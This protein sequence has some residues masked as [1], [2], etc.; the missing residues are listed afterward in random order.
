MNYH[1]YILYSPK[2]DKYYVGQT[3]NMKKRLLSHN[4]ISDLSY[5]SK[6]RPWELKLNLCFKTRANAMSAEK[7]LKKK[8]RDFI[9]RTFSDKDLQ[10]YI[11]NKFNS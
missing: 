1:C 8:P 7:Y 11:L 4:S 6:Y 3:K 9:K 2:F 5:T 10:Y